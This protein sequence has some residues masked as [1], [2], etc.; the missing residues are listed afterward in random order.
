[1]KQMVYVVVDKGIVVGVYDEYEDAEKV[2][3]LTATITPVVVDR[4][5]VNRKACNTP[6]EVI[7]AMQYELQNI[8]VNATI[9]DDDDDDYE[10]DEDEDEYEDDEDEYEEDE[11]EEDEEE[12]ED[13]DEDEKSEDE[14]SEI[15]APV[16]A[17]LC[18]LAAIASLGDA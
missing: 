5:D 15:P 17:I 16:R 1:M 10:D 12:D 7:N 9:M 3:S 6:S 8:G 11:D 4:T 13:E 14:E 2:A 18:A